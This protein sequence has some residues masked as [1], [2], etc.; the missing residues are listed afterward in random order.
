M[1]SLLL[2]F[3]DSWWP[4]LAEWITGLSTAALVVLGVFDWLLKRREKHLRISKA[5]DFD[6]NEIVAGLTAKGF[7]E[8]LPLAQ[9]SEMSSALSAGQ[10]IGLKGRP[11]IGKS[12][13]V[14]FHIRKL[15]I[16]ARRAERS[17]WDRI[18][19]LLA[20]LGVPGAR[21]YRWYVIRP[22]IQ[23]L[24]LAH[25]LRVRR[26]QY[27][28][29]LDDLNDYVRD[30]DGAGIL[31]LIA[32]LQQQSQAGKLVVVAT[33]RSTAPEEESVAVV[34]KIFT[35]WKW[36]DL[37]D[38]QLD[39]G[40]KLAQLCGVGIERWDGTPLSVKQPS[41]EMRIK[42]DRLRDTPSARAILHC[43][44]FLRLCGVSS[45]PR[46]VLKSVCA[47]Q[48][49]NVTS[50]DF[51]AGLI[52]IN[53]AG[54]FKTGTLFVEVY[55]PYIEAV[56]DWVPNPE[57]DYVVLR[58]V[59]VKEGRLPELMT[60]AGHWYGQNRLTDAE[61]V[62]R[63]CIQIAP[64][65]AATYYLL[66]SILRRKEDLQ[67]AQDAYAKALRINPGYARARSLLAAVWHKQGRREDAEKAYLAAIKR[68]PQMFEALV[69]L[70]RV[71]LD[72]GELER[73]KSHFEQAIHIRPE[74]SR[75]RCF[76]GETLFRLERFAEAERSYTDAIELDTQL[77]E[78]RI[79]YTRVLLKKENYSAAARE[80]RHA[81]RLMPNSAWAHA[82]LGSALGHLKQFDEAETAYRTAIKLE[83]DAF[84]YKV[85]LGILFL[86]AKKYAEA[87]DVFQSI[88][89]ARP[90]LWRSYSYLAEAQ[91]RLQNFEE[92]EKAYLRAHEIQPQATEPLTGL[93]MTL[94]KK[95]DFKGAES[96]LRMVLDLG[97]GNTWVC[98][99]LG[100][101][102][103]KQ[104][105]RDEADEMYEKGLSDDPEV[106]Q[107][108]LR[109]GDLHFRNGDYSRAERAYRG[110]LR[111]E[112]KNLEAYSRLAE[113]LIRQGKNA[114]LKIVEEKM[115]ELSPRTAVIYRG[116]G[117]SA[118]KC[119]DWST[120]ERFFRKAIEAEP[121]TGRSYQHL[122]DALLRQDRVE[123]AARELK[124]ALELNP[125]MSKSHY[126]IGKTLVMQGDL[127]KAEAA[128]RTSIE[129]KGTFADAHQ[130]LGDILAGRGRLTEAAEEHRTA[131]ELTQ[132]Q[133]K[134]AGKVKVLRAGMTSSE[135]IK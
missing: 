79:G 42:Y 63:G 119:G 134:P 73:A 89:N 128:L 12:H 29:L 3:S 31:D 26:R 94:L 109:R 18:R 45:I 65:E 116:P 98:N 36:I 19:E 58:D 91:A 83:S 60:I 25:Q 90:T 126:L 38:W 105:R 72:K 117:L 135:N 46:A 107:W 82:L 32:A 112:S 67:G 41:T 48:I 129:I 87:R 101:A 74:S 20:R 124:H 52:Q 33:L 1:A 130:L 118:M 2:L 13:A 95:N 133:T 132:K 54:F 123:E 93:G 68:H 78:A 5:E 85:G 97:P 75:A 11:G 80:A 62:C 8:Y 51:E 76:L 28:L 59:L 122:G 110:V 27:I 69:G 71:L 17:I 7:S 57:N 104:G 77:A 37:P 49:F 44:R 114:E 24:R 4:Q 127:K 22:P 113:T 14:S 15:G 16:A 55:D 70:G 108:R 56:Y 88:V 125:K 84:D 53:R 10:S 102:L 6:P 103:D 111:F 115:S 34:S 61:W 99:R 40:R 64:S 43:I 86:D 106:L 81:I 39:Q 9:D 35:K 121:N 50:S 30:D 23:A 21:S 100:D 131:L 120:A 92:A 66:G 47:T 96:V